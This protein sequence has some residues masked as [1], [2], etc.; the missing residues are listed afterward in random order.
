ME[1]ITVT[2]NLSEEDRKRLDLIIEALEKQAVKPSLE[3]AKTA[4]KE[5]PEE[6]P[7][8]E[9]KVEEKPVPEP[10]EQKEPTGPEYTI[11]D[12]RAKAAELIASGKKA[13]C[14]DI[15]KAYA[16]KV[17]AIPPEKANE[18]MGKLNE[19]K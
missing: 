9:E 14:R 5:V 18:V 12:V 11:D 19:V 6:E 15:I 17:S 8:A 13:E 1:K 16:E 7:K 10:E 2:V 4:E 3:A